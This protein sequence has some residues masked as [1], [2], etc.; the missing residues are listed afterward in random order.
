MH[1]SDNLKFKIYKNLIDIELIKYSYYTYY[2]KNNENR[3]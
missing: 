1:N 3:N 2:V